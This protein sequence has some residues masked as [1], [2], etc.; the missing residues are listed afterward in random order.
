MNTIEK[1]NNAFLQSFIKMRQGLNV[2]DLKEK[3][4][5]IQPLPEPD[6]TITLAYIISKKPGNKEVI[7]YFRNKVKALERENA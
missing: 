1:M 7:E 5:G 4:K 2:S 3:P 6:Q